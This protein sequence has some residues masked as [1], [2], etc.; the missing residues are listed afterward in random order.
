MSI[1]NM[2]KIKAY[3]IGKFIVYNIIIL[4]LEN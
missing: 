2:S 4:N 1:Y 3:I